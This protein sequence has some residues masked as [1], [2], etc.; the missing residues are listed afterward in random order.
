VRRRA[1]RQPI[2][3]EVESCVAARLGNRRESL[4]HGIGVEVRQRE[5]DGAARPD[6][7]TDDGGRDHV[8]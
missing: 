4:V 8:S 2:A 1:H 5:V 3:R 7:L 6:L